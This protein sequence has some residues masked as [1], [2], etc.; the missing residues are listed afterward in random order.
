MDTT[1]AS[2]QTQ[3]QDRVDAGRPASSAGSYRD[4]AT[5]QVPRPR[6]KYVN[7]NEPANCRRFLSDFGDRLTIAYDEDDPC[8]DIYALEDNGRLSS[9]RARMLLMQTG[10]IYLQAAGK[11]ANWNLTDKEDSV[12]F[13]DACQVNQ[14]SYFD[15]ISRV[16]RLVLMDLEES[17]VRHGVRMVQRAEM[18]SNR[19]YLGAPNGI[20]DL[21]TGKLAPPETARKLLVSASIPDDYDPDALHPDCDRLFP[22]PGEGDSDALQR[23]KI[24]AAIL[25]NWPRRQ[26]IAEL[27]PSGT[28]KT[29]EKNAVQRALGDQYVVE[30][31]PVAWAAPGRGYGGDPHNG[32][33]LKLQLPAR[34]A[35]T[36]EISGR[37]DG[38]F[39]KKAAG[40]EAYISARNVAEKRVTFRPSAFAWFQTNVDRDHD[41]VESP[42]LNLG[43]HGNSDD[44]VALR[45]RVKII[46]RPVLDGENVNPTLLDR[47][48][49]L[50]DA[51]DRRFRQAVAARLVS[52]C[53]AHPGQPFPEDTPTMEERLHEQAQ[54]EMP[55]WQRQWLPNV[56]TAGSED[57]GEAGGPWATS[58]DIYEDFWS[59]WEDNGDGRPPSKAVV[60]KAVA[61][62]YQVKPVKKQKR[63]DGKLKTFSIYPGLVLTGSASPKSPTQN[64]KV[65]REAPRRKGPTAWTWRD[66]DSE[67]A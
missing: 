9:I 25:Q 5:D 56:L 23:Q 45:S 4:N 37:V 61:A 57:V 50:D 67:F 52:Y 17:G 6:L 44:A 8:V 55:L 21:H 66:P 41:G 26:L 30:M 40:G 1:T 20:I 43:I 13:R 28:G 64:P 29:T 63:I 33:R 39:I 53:A 54:R 11:A 27:C 65:D 42:V 47:G 12:V 31:D 3:S 10:Q 7:A 16:V 35:Y 58:T 62:F 2:E 46:V 60:G 34:I 59:W 14:A 48:S 51:D 19:R 32:E 22:P 38:A 24:Y 18:D 36:S 15:K 49:D